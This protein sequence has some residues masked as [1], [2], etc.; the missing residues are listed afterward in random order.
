MIQH[1]P[2]R[3]AI[4]LVELLVIIAIIGLLLALLLPAV[5]RLRTLAEEQEDREQLRVLGHAWM[6]YA[7]AHQGKTLQHNNGAPFDA[8][9]KKLSGYGDIND[10]LVSPA[11]VNRKERLAYMKD[12]PDRLC[13]SFVLNPYFCSTIKDPVTKRELSCER[14]S[15]CTSLSTAIAILPV[16]SQAGVPGPGYIT[17][18]GWM[19]P[20]VSMAWNRTIGV[21]G[22]QPDRFSSPAIDSVPGRANYFFADGHVESITADQIKHWINTNK[23]FLIPQ[24]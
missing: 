7:R 21:T 18:I 24:R 14:I 4:T 9:L 19:A 17:P 15:E 3:R 16:S 5:M 20:P 1:Q 8:W 22:I 11:D 10:Y 23:Q 12:N 13:T 2:S 6:A